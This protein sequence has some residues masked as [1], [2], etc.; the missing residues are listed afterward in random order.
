MTNMLR[1]DPIRKELRDYINDCAD[2]LYDDMDPGHRHMRYHGDARPWSDMVRELAKGQTSPARDGSNEASRLRDAEDL[3]LVIETAALAN[4]DL[5]I[6]TVLS[7]ERRR[8]AVDRIIDRVDANGR[9]P[10][11]PRCSTRTRP[12]YGDPIGEGIIEDPATGHIRAIATRHFDVDIRCLPPRERDELP[13]G[14]E[15]TFRLK[16]VRPNLAR[17]EAESRANA[18]GAVEVEGMAPEV[19]LAAEIRRAL[20]ERTDRVQRAEITCAADPAL[21]A[22]IRFRRI[23]SPDDPSRPVADV[24]EIG[25]RPNANLQ[26][27]FRR[28]DDGTPTRHP[29]IAL[30]LHADGTVYDRQTLTDDS[31]HMGQLLSMLTRETRDD[32]RLLTRSLTRSHAI[33]DATLRVMSAASPVSRTKPEEKPEPQWD[34]SSDDMNQPI[35]ENPIPYEI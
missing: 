15:R 16:A 11:E 9:N 27:L 8:D 7:T 18:P 17:Q 26:M 12:S 4:Q 13:D 2:M 35:R 5:L 28:H 24:I 20:P 3:P 30:V 22:P 1:D 21:S 33:D 19:D 32:M 34:G 14:R 25:L 29:E 10:I 31:T 6:H 23:P